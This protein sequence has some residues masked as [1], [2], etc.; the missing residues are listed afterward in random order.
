MNNR[1]RIFSSTLAVSLVA[2]LGA[3]TAQAAEV[4]LRAESF[5]K[6]IAGVDVTMW[7]YSSCDSSFTTC[8]SPSSPGPEINVPAGDA[9]GTGGVPSLTIHLLNGL[10]GP[11][12]EATSVMIPGQAKLMTPQTFIDSAT[13]PRTR[14]RA[15]DAEATVGGPA[16]DYFWNNLKA[17][18]YLYQSASHVQ[19]Q[20]QM[21]LYGAMVHDAG[22]GLAYADVP[23]AQS[24][25]IVFSEIDPALHD[26][27]PKAANLTVDGYRPSYFLL[28]GEPFV[29]PA[30]ALASIGAGQALLLRLVNAGLQNRAPQ[31]VGGYYQI[32]AEDG[33]SVPVP[34]R[35]MQYNTL[36]PAGKALDV[37]FTGSAGSYPLYDRRLGLVNGL[38]T[39]G[40]QQGSIVVSP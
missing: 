7:G 39:N 17:G 38:S 35:R 22:L 36:L 10:S 32:V 27:V 13:P 26:P 28:N 23:Y 37:L 3:T 30:P 19:L 24:K 8:G 31:L 29:D 33:H 1:L 40:G 6:T 2:T 12:A 21:G 14:I 15:F 11:T 18:T 25:T 20:V 34:I 5:T 4:W 9:S 16:V